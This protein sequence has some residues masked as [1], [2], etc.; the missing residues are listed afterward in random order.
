MTFVQM[1]NEYIV[2]TMCIMVTV[3]F[4]GIRLGYQRGG[5]NRNLVYIWTLLIYVIYVLVSPA[6]FYY[7]ER[8]IIIGTDISAYYGTGFAYNTLALICF[9]FGYWIK[10]RPSM[11]TWLKAPLYILE[12]PKK[13]ITILFYSM[14]GIVLL[15][16]AV[17]GADIQQVF[18]GN[19]VVGM[20]ASGGSYFL[21]NF[22]DSLICVLVLAYFYDIPTRTLLIWMAISFF[23][24]S[25]LGFRYR[26]VLTLFGILFI[27]LFKNKISVGRIAIGAV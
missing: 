3:L 10:G 26:I 15:N 9:V 25:L 11:D 17:G 6:Y 22:T 14:Y 23:L 19:E 7:T 18:I 24:F 8:K 13:I 5:W 12:N 16:L 4:I 27:Y 2:L 20:G 21:Q 1:L